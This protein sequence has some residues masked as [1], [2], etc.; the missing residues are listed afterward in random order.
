MAASKALPARGL[1]RATASVGPPR[2]RRT[3]MKE[4]FAGVR[5]AYFSLHRF[6]RARATVG[7]TD[8]PTQSPIRSP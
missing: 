1:R 8:E 5:A 2:P 4:T 6:N 3:A 7:S